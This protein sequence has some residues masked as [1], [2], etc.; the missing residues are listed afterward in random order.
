MDDYNKTREELIIE[1]AE[2]RQKVKSSS[3]KTT[4]SELLRLEA[5]L[6]LFEKRYRAAL[7]DRAKFIKQYRPGGIITH[8]NDAFINYLGIS[9]EELIG[10]S[11]YPFLGKGDIKEL[12][13]K[14]EALTPEQPSTITENRVLHPDGAVR[15]HRW[16]HRA[17]F[18]A[19]RKITGYEAEGT[20]IT[21]Q[22]SAIKALRQLEARYRSVIG[23]SADGFSVLDREGR[24]ID[25]NDAYVRR[26]GYRREELLSM[27]IS[28]LDAKEDPEDTAGRMQRIVGEG[29]DVFETLHRKKD[30]GVLLL[31][32][33]TLYSL[34]DGGRFISYYYDLTQRRRNQ[35]ALNRFEER[36]YIAFHSSPVGMIISARKDDR[37]IDANDAFCRITGYM[38]EEL[39]N[40]TSFELELWADAADRQRLLTMLD[41]YGSARNVEIGLLT[42]SGGVLT[43]QVSVAAIEL[44]DE[45]CFI[46]S[47]ID[48]TDRKKLEQAL[49][50][51]EEK[52]RAFFDY[53]NDMVLVADTEGRLVDANKKAV[54]LL[55][56]S[57][58]ELTSMHIYQIHPIEE[59]ER[60]LDAFRE[61]TTKN[62]G[63]LLDSVVT[64]RGNK[65]IYV[66][67]SGS[68]VKRNEEVVAVIEI[69]RDITERRR[70]EIELEGYR[71]H[72]EELVDRRTRE[73][74]DLNAQLRQSQKLE[75][76]G[77]LAGGIAHDFS[78]IL[79]TIKGSLYLIQKSLE[80]GNPLM[81]YTGRALSSVDKATNVT[82]GL[83]AF[84]R[85]QTIDLHP[86]DFNEIIRSTAKLL[87]QLIGEHI[88]L[89]M[90]LPD[91]KYTVMV[92][93][94]QIEQIILNLATNARDAMPDGGTLILQTLPFTMDEAFIKE[95]GYGS[96]GQYVQ[97]TVADTGVG[98]DKEIREKIFDPFFTTKESGK[99]SGLG[100]SVTY[101]IVKQHGG[102][103]DFE[104]LA[105]Q[106]TSF[107]IYIPLVD[108]TALSPAKSEVSPAEGKGETILLAEDD[109]D[110][111]AIMAE[112]LLLSGYKVIEA[113]D[114]N[115]AV[116]MFKQHRD[117]VDLAFLDIRMPKKKRT[118]GLRRDHKDKP[119]GQSPF[120]KRVYE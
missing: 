24:I 40:K 27:H 95:H 91:R 47:A 110:A 116:K 97:L 120:H 111:R 31:E 114:G 88:E 54:E 20:D 13:K 1:L 90:M 44:A 84:S 18:N 42:R 74:S 51:S 101:G 17:L 52:F 77:L 10:K 50:E 28:D 92:D 49:Q 46:S 99:R 6:R 72:L 64:T 108:R 19:R 69:L 100:L 38:C 21:G 58:A 5:K 80:P 12:T 9:P 71:N 82:Q 105:G 8:A 30:G 53:A 62:S 43:L 16:T 37:I 15:W 2:L 78:N 4:K 55:G 98:I 25:V 56:Y 48:I 109:R 23:S 45:Q 70:T 41:T 83:L 81:K 33:H 57:R 32:V 26:S 89:R 59:L 63:I 34:I 65:K 35:E 107:S 94:N 66:D 86:W 117:E 7:E 68:A 87:L 119:G 14:L 22:K 3:Q 96:A 36:F 60:T 39:L 75:A 112:V 29:S 85:K 93:R 11:F 102:F 76:V 113:D 103:L 106:G 118:G 79:T 115:D 73:I 67:I 104:S 61:M